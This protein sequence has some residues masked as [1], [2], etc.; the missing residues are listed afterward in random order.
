MNQLVNM[1][2]AFVLISGLNAQPEIQLQLLSDDFN[3]PVDIASAG[4]DRLFVVEKR[5]IIKIVS[6]TGDIESTPFLNIDGRVNSGASE[7]GLLGLV[8]HPNYASN[9]YFFVNYTRSG[10][11]TRISRFSVNAD[12]PNVADPSSEKILL[13]IPQP[14]SNHNAGDIN[15]GPDG[16]LYFGLGDGGGGGDPGDHSQTRNDLLGKMIRIDVD[17]GDPYQIPNDNPFVND[18][19]TL[20][21]IWAIGLRNPWRFSFDRETGDMWI[22]DVGQNAFEEI[23]LQPADSDGGENYGWRCYEG[24]STFNT[25][26]CP[27]VSAFTMPVHVYAHR[28]NN[29]R[30]SVTG[31]FVYR[32]QAYPSLKGKY[33]YGDYCTGEM[34]TLEPDGDNNWVNTEVTDIPFGNWSTFGED[35]NGELYIANLN[36]S[37]YRITSPNTTNVQTYGAP[38]KIVVLTNP[39][40]DQLQLTVSTSHRGSAEFLL[41]DASGKILHRQIEELTVPSTQVSIERDDLPTGV[42][43]VV[44]QL[45]NKKLA[46]K[47]VKQ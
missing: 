1:L 35:N 44:A 41:T 2:F 22:A 4:D 27:G 24:N 19:F 28:G 12:D 40:K 46:K 10:G 42:Y 30:A 21:E 11:T 32:G 13:E 3:S 20:D 17:S 47:V 36:G 15:F 16:M 5:G 18:D 34:W 37:I 14:Q 9:G 25:S 33:I 7:R 6:K 23:H 39:F 29:C 45:G 26:G 38:D 43:Y 31:G 8:F